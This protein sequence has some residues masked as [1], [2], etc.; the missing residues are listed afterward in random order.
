MAKAA[1]VEDLASEDAPSES[2][3]R[4]YP[5]TIVALLSAF[6]FFAALVKNLS[7]IHI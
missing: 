6:A 5:A 2:L 1:P 7:L 3:L 4:R